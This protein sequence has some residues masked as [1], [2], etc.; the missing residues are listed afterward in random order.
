MHKLTHIA[1][2]NKEPPQNG[3]SLLL[4]ILLHIIPASI[5]YNAIN[6]VLQFLHNILFIPVKK[7]LTLLG[8]YLTLLKSFFVNNS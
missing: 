4:Y 2:S 1:T 5:F 6:S 3:G 7:V 8:K